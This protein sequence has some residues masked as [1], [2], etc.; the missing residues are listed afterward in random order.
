MVEYIICPG[1]LVLRTVKA[2]GP[3]SIQRLECGYAP[4]LDGVV[5]VFPG[6]TSGSVGVT[7]KDSSPMTWL[8]TATRTL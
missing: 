4:P 5:S 1:N 2:S 6:S 3:W 8:S 7:T